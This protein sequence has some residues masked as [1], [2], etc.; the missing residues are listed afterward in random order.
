MNLPASLPVEERQ[1]GLRTDCCTVIGIDELAKPRHQVCAH[2]FE[3][4]CRIY[5]P[6]PLSCPKFNCTWIR[7]DGEP[8]DRPDIAGVFFWYQLTHA[9]P[10]L[11][12]FQSIEE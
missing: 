4:G 1:C 9:E 2:S 3:S 8:G 10:T 12:G 7:G 6:R 5:E 11:W